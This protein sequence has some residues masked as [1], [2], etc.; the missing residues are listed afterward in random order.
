MSSN[1][2]I[3]R[4]ESMPSLAVISSRIRNRAAAFAVCLT[5]IS[6][7]PWARAEATSSADGAGAAEPRARHGAYLRLGLGAGS[8][9]A[10]QGASRATLNTADGGGVA[11]NLAVGG[12]LSPLVTLGGNIVFQQLKK[13]TVTFNGQGSQADDN[14]NVAVVGVMLEGYASRTSGFHFGGMIG[15]AALSVSTAKG[16]T[17]NSASGVGYALGVGY[18]FRISPTWYLGLGAH[19]LGAHFVGDRTSANGFEQVART[20]SVTADALNF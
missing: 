2:L 13:P 1:P 3:H 15:P 17:V 19:Y 18:E 10:T 14:W 6:F 12:A 8:G 7:A 16:D 5:T 20:F 11:F 4:T 9:H